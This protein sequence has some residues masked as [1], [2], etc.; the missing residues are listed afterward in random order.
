MTSRSKNDFKSINQN[1][2]K[3]LT[4]NSVQFD[5][6]SQK[7]KVSPKKR[8]VA[9]NIHG[10]PLDKITKHQMSPE[11]KTFHSTYLEDYTGKQNQRDGGQELPDIKNSQVNQGPTDRRAESVAEQAN[12]TIQDPKLGMSASQTSF[13]KSEFYTIDGKPIPLPKPDP[14]RAFGDTPY[15]SGDE[16]KYYGDMRNLVYRLKYKGPRGSLYQKDYVPHPLDQQGPAWKNDFY[17]T[18]S[19]GKVNVEYGTT[20]RTD[21]KD[22]NQGPVKRETMNW[23]PATS[24]IPFNGRSMYKANFI[25]YGCN[26]GALYKVKQIPTVIPELPIDARSI[27]RDDFKRHSDAKPAELI[28]PA[29]FHQKK[30]PLSPAIP[31]QGESQAMKT[32]KPF[33]VTGPVEKHRPKDSYEPT[34]TTGGL[35]RTTY[36]NDFVKHPE[37]MNPREFLIPKFNF[38]P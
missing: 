14:Y 30:S 37:S 12:Q 25:D 7:S 24:G 23:K 4:A 18:N 13:Q 34:A 28:D 32:Y 5:T 17:G 6:L 27:Y 22:W 29:I 19:F 33:K 16:A 1:T 2:Q 9:D 8:E 20:N 10:K 15:I 3:G 38:I 11:T 35:Y 26:T 36:R 31:F 21:F